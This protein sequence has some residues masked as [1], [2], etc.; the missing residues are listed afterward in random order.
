MTAG[1]VGVPA[2]PPRAAELLR[3]IDTGA[4]LGASRQLHVL[5]DVL[6]EMAR[7]HGQDAPTLTAGAQSLVA[8]VTRTRGTS[9]HAV[10]N[11][12]EQMARPVLSVSGRN[13]GEDAG[14]LLV[15]SVETFRRLLDTAQASV[16]GHGY[17]VLRPYGRILAYDYSSTVAQVV[18]DVARLAGGGRLTVFVPEARS[19][20]GGRKYLS[21]WS[22]LEVTV[23]LVPDAAVGWALGRCDAAV[24]GAETLSGEGGCYNTIGTAV[25][26]QGARRAGVP[27]YVLS[28]LLKTDLQDPDGRRAP[29]SLDFLKRLEAATPPGS[30]LTVQGEFPDLDYTGPGDITG[31]VTEAGL[32][33]PEQLRE[34]AAPSLRP[35]TPISE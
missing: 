23:R 25:V 4:V 8:H 19:L 7:V 3:S 33:R 28:V 24:A 30:P 1:P 31:L 13:T 12:I 18:S 35:R 26:A 29:A 14:E 10:A 15:A 27:F 2:L 20:D 16:R 34:L 22:D 32:I 21:D 5:G 6:T 11:G 17:E 9:S